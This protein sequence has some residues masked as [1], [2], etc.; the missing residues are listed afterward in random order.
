MEV[1]KAWAV[2]QNTD[3]CEGRGREYVQ[4]Y[5]SDKNVALALAEKNYVMGMNC[6]VKQVEVFH[7]NGKYFPKTAEIYFTEHPFDPEI[8]ELR[9]AFYN[10]A[11]EL[12]LTEEQI[13]YIR[14]EL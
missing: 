1:I 14:K 2:L 6:P 5:C 4:Y 8:R 13:E 10:R 9:T 11:R 3:G 12:G 7:H